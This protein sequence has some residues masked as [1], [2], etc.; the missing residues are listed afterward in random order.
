MSGA[1][2]LPASHA[3]PGGDDEDPV[4]QPNPPVA[5]GQG[6]EAAEPPAPAPSPAVGRL[7]A[8]APLATSPR[9]RVGRWA[10]WVFGV[11]FALVMSVFLTGL[12]KRYGPD[13]TSA[14]V[15]AY[16]VTSDAQVSVTV[17]VD[18]DPAQDAVCLLRSRGAA[19]NEVGHLELRVPAAPQG[20]KRVKVTATV[21]TTGRGVTGESGRCLDVA[22]GAPPPFGE[23]PPVPT[24]PDLPRP[25]LLGGS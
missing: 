14:S 3:A 5:A 1:G 4:T 17:Q 25:G 19:G 18:R 8:A 7:L 10:P 21:P 24:T 6:P 2:D 23:P 15:L 9:S 22:P 20:R 12:V 13:G 16:T 11:S